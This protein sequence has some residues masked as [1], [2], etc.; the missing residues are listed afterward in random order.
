MPGDLP[1]PPT[2][3]TT[4]YPDDS[5]IVVE[6][7]AGLQVALQDAVTGDVVYVADGTTID[8][9]GVVNLR[10]PAGV[11]LVGGRDLKAGRPGPRL[12]VGRDDTAGTLFVARG[13]DVRIT[14]LRLL[15]PRP[16]RYEIADPNSH[17]RTGVH[18]LGTG[19]EV[20]NCEF[21]GWPHAA[22]AVGSRSHRPRARV[23]SCVIHHNALAGLGY[24]VTVFDGHA[25]IEDCTFNH[26]RHAVDGFGHPGCGYEARNNVIGPTTYSHVFDMHRLDENVGEAEAIAGRFVDIHHNT[27]LATSDGD[28]TPQEAIAVRGVPTDRVRIW[29]NQFAHEGPP[30]PPGGQGDAYRQVNVSTWKRFDARDNAFAGEPHDRA[31][32]PWYT[33]RHR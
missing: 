27:V 11:R 5:D 2:S 4:Y 7:A 12:T 32:C 14:G 6:T 10:V 25:V 31:G 9:T 8:L 28:G 1:D 30:S 29:R 22:V 18:L 26:N 33:G 15:G 19:G 17:D 23:T 16:E 13:D 21:T 3:T 20:A 24:G